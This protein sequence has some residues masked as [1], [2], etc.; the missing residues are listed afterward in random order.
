M[1]ER[2]KAGLRGPAKTVLNERIFSSADGQQVLTSM[3]TEYAVDGRILKLRIGN[4]DGSTWITSH[5][6]SADG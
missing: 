6:Y 5:T 2:D 1:S 3:T 4:S